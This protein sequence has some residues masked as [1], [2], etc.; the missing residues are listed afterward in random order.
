MSFGL[1]TASL[2]ASVYSQSGPTQRVVRVGVCDAVSL[3]S[4]PEAFVEVGVEGQMFT[5][6]TNLNGSADI[7]ELTVPPSVGGEEVLMR[8][9]IEVHR[10]N[11]V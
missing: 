2:V 1:V 6:V 8:V 10:T 4:V 11:Y 9:A 7:A 5:S 3:A